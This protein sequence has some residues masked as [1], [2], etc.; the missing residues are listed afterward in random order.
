MPIVEG[1]KEVKNAFGSR[2]G[3][4]LKDMIYKVFDE[5][6]GRR[7]LGEVIEA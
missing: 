4:S 7:H 2:S 1:M 6:V 5:E 3:S